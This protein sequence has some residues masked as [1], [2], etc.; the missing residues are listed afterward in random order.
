MNRKVTEGFVGENVFVLVLY[1]FMDFIL[2]P[3]GSVRLRGLDGRHA[4][5]MLLCWWLFFLHVDFL[6]ARGSAGLGR[7]RDR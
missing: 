4:K 7:V 3:L 5:E 6:L 2:V 1:L